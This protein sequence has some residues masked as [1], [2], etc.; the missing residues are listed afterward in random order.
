[1]PL[2][3]WAAVLHCHVASLPPFVDSSKAYITVAVFDLAYVFVL[4]L[5]GFMTEDRISLAQR[6]ILQKASARPIRSFINFH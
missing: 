4:A 1:M 5:F 6:R 3:L 2:Q